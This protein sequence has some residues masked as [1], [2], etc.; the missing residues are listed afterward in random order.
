MRPLTITILRDEHQAL[1]A[2]LRSLLLMLD[3]SARQGQPP[4]FAV[5]RAMLLYI[6]EFPERQHHT[7][8][9]QW[10]FPK[11]RL[12]APMLAETLDRLDREHANG[13]AAVRHLEHLL[14]SYEVMGESRREPF[15]L[16]A[17]RYVEFYLAHM[18]LEEQTVLPA[19][20]AH[21]LPEDWTELDQAFAARRDPLAGGEIPE[22]YRP[23]FQRILNTAPSPIGLGP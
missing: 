5:L 11:L 20:I 22:D 23:L 13:E 19:A 3:V 14:L 16:A 1:A 10:L 21:L 8:E 17:R 9:S 2:M 4:D 7:E 15:E 18:G 12:R 6:D